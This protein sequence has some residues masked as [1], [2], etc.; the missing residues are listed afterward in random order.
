MDRVVVV[1]AS[2]AGLRAAEELRDPGL[3]RHD[4]GRRRRAAPPVRPAAAVEA[5]AGRQASRRRPPRSSPAQRHARRPRPRLAPRASR[6]PA[7]TSAA[8]E[9]L[10][11]G[12]ERLPFDG[13]VIATGAS[14]RRL[15]GTDHLDGVHTLRTL[16]DCARH[17]RRA[18]GRA[19]PGRGGR[20]R[21][22]RRR[23]GG[24]VPRPRPRGH[25]WSRR[26][27]CPL[28]RGRRPGAR[29][30]RGRPAPRPRRRRAPRRRAS[31]AS[32]AATGSSSVR[33]TDGTELDV[34]L[35]VS[36][37]ASAPNTEW[38][39]GSGLT[40]DNGVLCDETC[41]AAPGVVAAGDVARWPNRALRR[42]RCASSTGTTPSRWAPTRPARCWPTPPAAR[43]SPTSRCRG[44]GPTS[45]TARSSWPAG[46]RPTTRS[47]W[48]PGSVEERKFVAF[49]GRGGRV[50]G[51]LGMNMP[52]KVMRWRGL[53]EAGA[54]WDDALAAAAAM[55]GAAFLLLALALVAAV[56]RLGRRATSEQQ[57]PRVPL[58]A[59][60]AG[61]ARR[62]PRSP[63]TRRRR[64][65]H[66]V[67]GRARAA[68]CSATSS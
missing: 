43:A 68:A 2:L 40:L 62:P 17:P 63:S 28:E 46:P 50:V 37:S 18:R 35:V 19:P 29:R 51:V 20:R 39:E 42:G 65:A 67:R 58:Q 47:R 30:G 38:L 9:V 64:R 13:L 8:R 52:A 41:L 25:A 1:G 60:H 16:D 49:Y 53:V 7:S 10:L 26:C 54:S 27:R 45:T 21:V 15:P 14:P 24:H 31:C 61:A 34:D 48:W 5:G 33:L 12:G 6:P 23:G 66:L 44:S 32:T 59:A 56:R 3:R 36:A 11:G 22:H 4:H 57:G 55:T